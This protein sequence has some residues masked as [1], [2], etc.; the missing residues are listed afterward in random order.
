MDDRRPVRVGLEVV[1]GSNLVA[2]N[3]I[4]DY[5][6]FRVVQR[7]RPERSDR[8]EVA[9]RKAHHVSAPAGERLAVS[10]AERK[11]VDGFR[12]VLAGLPFFGDGRSTEEIELVRVGVRQLPNSVVISQ[13]FMSLPSLVLA[14]ALRIC[15]PISSARLSPAAVAASSLA[16]SNSLFGPMF[17]VSNRPRMTR[18]APCGGL[19]RIPR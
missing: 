4:F 6:S 7:N 1:V 15:G 10:I 19:C 5:E 11:R 17:K 3:G 14:Y 18:S 2:L 12:R 8:W 16:G 9:L 13:P